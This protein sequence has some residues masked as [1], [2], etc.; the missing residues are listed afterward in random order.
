MFIGLT[1]N[2]CYLN[3]LK[4]L[5]D[6]HYFMYYFMVILMQSLLLIFV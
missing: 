1:Y 5:F 2:L 6:S 3:L 4:E